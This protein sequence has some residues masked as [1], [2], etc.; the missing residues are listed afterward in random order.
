MVQKSFLCHYSPF[1]NAAFNGRFI[2]G[3]T[4]EMTLEDVETDIFDLLVRWVYE[5]RIWKGE[6]LSSC[7]Q[8]SLQVID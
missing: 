6:L 8:P 2:E 1:F 5:Q 3:E 4:Q 7:M